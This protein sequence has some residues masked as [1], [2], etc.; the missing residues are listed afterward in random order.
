V[1]REFPARGR[2]ALN[3]DSYDGPEHYAGHYCDHDADKHTSDDNA[4][5]VPIDHYTRYVA[6]HDRFS[7]NDFDDLV[8]S[9]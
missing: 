1:V 7:S 8:T 4:G 6:C 9:G 2:F 5:Y 3:Y